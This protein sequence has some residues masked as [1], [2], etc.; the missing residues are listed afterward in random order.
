MGSLSDT[1]YEKRPLSLMFSS[2]VVQLQNMVE[3]SIYAVF[4]ACGV[5]ESVFGHSP[6]PHLS[7][8]LLFSAPWIISGPEK[9]V[10]SKQV[11]DTLER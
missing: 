9:C 7:F 2:C 3:E 1:C 8:P 5:T 4:G 6:H 11:K 10:I